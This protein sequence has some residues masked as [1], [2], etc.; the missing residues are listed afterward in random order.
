MSGR[1]DHPFPAPPCLLVMDGHAYAYRAFHAIR[2]LK[3]PGGAPTNAIFGFIRAVEK[4]RELF[5]PAYLAVLWDGGLA[6]ERLAEWPAYKSQRPPM[7]DDLRVQ[8]D[9]INAWLDAA[10]LAW[11]CREGLEADDGIAT[12]SRRAAG[13]GTDVIIASPDKDFLQLVSPRIGLV[14]PADKSQAVWREAQVEAKTGVS[15]GQIVDW[16]SLVGDSVDNIP[17]VSGVG[18][19]TAA[20]LLRQFGSV[21]ALYER[22]AEVKPER[23]RE[24]LGAAGPAVRRNQRLIALREDFPLDCDLEKLRPGLGD[25]ARQNELCARWGFRARAAAAAGEPV[26][27][28]DELFAGI[29]RQENVDKTRV[30]C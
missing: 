27:R 13:R 30:A 1:P 23:V 19:K 7:P 11:F 2:G 9:D 20:S 24:A 12:L 29:F 6:A 18:P 26:A 22:L 10:G 15:P 16:L 3:A 28:Q 4:L 8:L 17:G 14:N 5:Q 21:G 25:P